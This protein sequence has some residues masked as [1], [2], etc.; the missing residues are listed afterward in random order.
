LTFDDQIAALRQQREGHLLA[1]IV[2]RAL[3]YLLHRKSIDKLK[4][5]EARSYFTESA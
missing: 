2:L 1:K 4:D 5:Q 3:S